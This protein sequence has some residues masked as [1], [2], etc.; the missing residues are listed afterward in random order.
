MSE[1]FDQHRVNKGMWYHLLDQIVQLGRGKI[2]FGEK[3][4]LLQGW[5]GRGQ[6]DY[7][8]RTFLPPHYSLYLKQW[9]CDSFNDILSEIMGI[10]SCD[11]LQV[12][13]VLER[14][15]FDSGLE[16]ETHLPRVMTGFFPL[17]ALRA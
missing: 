8:V 6:W 11:G 16:E 12:Q 5:K 1:C 10:F 17:V 2:R 9:L 15:T 3:R 7:L 13:V 4:A 14:I